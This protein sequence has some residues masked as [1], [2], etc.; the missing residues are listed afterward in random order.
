VLRVR[1][2]VHNTRTGKHI[3]WYLAVDDG[4]RDRVRALRFDDD[5]GPVQ[6]D[7][8]EAEVTPLLG[9]VRALHRRPRPR[10]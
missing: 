9:Y 4:S 10:R 5:P 6:G 3:S 2:Q 8:V 7:R 1:V